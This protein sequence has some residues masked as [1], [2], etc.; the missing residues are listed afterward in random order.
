MKLKKLTFVICTLATLLSFSGCNNAPKENDIS[1]TK[2]HELLQN[3]EVIILDVRRPK[4]I[5]VG[6]IQSTALE[7]D[8]YEDNFMEE[9]ISKIT[10]EQT[11]YVYCKSGRRSGKTVAKLREL[12]YPNT[13]NVE[14][15]IT[16]WKAKGYKVE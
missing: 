5:A 4:E 11:V 2:L 12:G 16:A 10:K 6:K 7:A 9:V 3:D 8:F 13:H 14:G 15:G 1:V